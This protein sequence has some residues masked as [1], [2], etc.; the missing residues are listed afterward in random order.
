M[1]T[2]TKSLETFRKETRQWLEDHCPQ[3]MRIP[4]SSFE[5]TFMGGRNPEFT[6][7]D[8]RIWFERMR[9]RGWTAPD[10]PQVYGGGG[11][12]QQEYRVLKEEMSLINCRAP[13]WSFGL[14]MLGP[15]LLQFG[16]EKQKKK[17]LTEIARGEVWWCQGYSEPGAGSDLAN[18]QT[19]AVDKGDHYEV[20]GQ[21]VWTS[22]ADKADMIFCLVRTDPN[23]SKHTGISFLLIDMTSKGVSTQPI[24]LIS[25]KSPFCETFFD[26]VRVSKE[27][28]VGAENYG[29]TIAKYLLTHERSGIGVVAKSI[30]LYEKALAFNGLKKGPLP[31]PVLRAEIARWSI[32]EEA[33]KLTLERSSDES[34]EGKEPGAKSSFFK[35]YSSELNKRKY[36][37]LLSCGGHDALVWGNRY[38]EGKLARDMCRTKGNSIE[39]GT[40]EIQLNIISKHILRLPNK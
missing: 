9:D 18:L 5:E 39:G 24:K 33:M 32:D 17:Y 20:T 37:L 21:K 29:W 22:Y 36:E 7:E 35:Y 15:A 8:Q 30:P 11:L 12:N 40:S 31:D 3:S 4:V 26:R 10:W 34:K 19:R 16:T 2:Q 25:G 13:L 1:Q 28:I 6:S 14:M 23:A 27:N 38:E